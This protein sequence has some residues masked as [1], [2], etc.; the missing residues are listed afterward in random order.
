M[1]L[2]VVASSTVA[3]GGRRELPKSPVFTLLL[4]SPGLLP[5]RRVRMSCWFR[6]KA[7][8]DDEGGFGLTVTMER[9]SSTE[10]FFRERKDVQTER[11]RNAER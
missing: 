2:V 8:D 11:E 6:G 5:R 9:Q 3:C 4:L 1:I 10:L 7:C